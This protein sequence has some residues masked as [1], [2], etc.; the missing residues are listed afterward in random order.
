MSKPP[1]RDARIIAA[2]RESFPRMSAMAARQATDCW[3]INEVLH[4][5]PAPKTPDEAVARLRRDI[6]DE[7]KGSRQPFE[8]KTEDDVIDV[9]NDSADELEWEARVS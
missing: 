9:W 3:D 2:L 4:G 1:K 8:L 6:E 7:I 5:T